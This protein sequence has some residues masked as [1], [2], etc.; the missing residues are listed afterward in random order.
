VSAKWLRIETD[1]VDHPKVLRLAS[2][3]RDDEAAAGWYVMRAWSWVSRFCP[4]GQVRDIDGTAL[5][6]ACK[7]RGPAGELIAGFLESGWFDE[8]DKE[9]QKMGLEAHDWSEHQGRVASKAA[10]ERDRKRAYR[11]KRAAEDAE[12]VPRDN[13]G[14]SGGTDAGRPA[15]RDVTGRDVTGRIKDIPVE[16][17]STPSRQVELL[18]EKQL[19]LEDNLTDG[20]FQVFEHWRVTCA[21]PKAK[22]TPE[23]KRLIA[24]QLKLYTIAD[25]QRAIDGCAR[26]A[27]HM[28]ANDKHRKFDDIELILRDARH[29]ESFMAGTME[30]AA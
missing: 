17:S 5:E 10:K 15:Q 8:W 1:F 2:V 22:P 20:E 23:R 24:K 25:L 26:S 9:G 27:W 6:S 12:N 19:S 11:A 7:W 16:Q 3:L 14:T 29:I 28:G 30:N 18:D 21:H 4:T 13:D